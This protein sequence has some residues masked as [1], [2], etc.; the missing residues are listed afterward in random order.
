MEKLA[1]QT[2]TTSKLNPN[3]WNT[4]VVL[5]EAQSK[6]EESI[7]RFGMFKP[8]VCREL[9]DGRLEIIGGQH[10]WE[11]A[12]S[13]GM[14]E[15]PIVNLGL[16][17]DRKA[18]EISLVDNGRYGSDDS[19]RLAELLR[20][21]GTTD[22]LAEYLPYAVGDLAQIFSSTEVNLDDLSMDDDEEVEEQ[23]Q[24]ITKKS[25]MY[26]VM[27]FKVPVDDADFVRGVIDGISER[28]GFISSDSLTN[29]GD[30]LVWLC[31]RQRDAEEEE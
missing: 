28:Q 10:R 29:A 21:L 17:D 8:L 25:P 9:E 1:I 22:E 5:P 31:G 3:P 19:Q 30:A 15:V 11:A 4:N 7:R 18:K 24:E 23:V 16:I 12:K 27:R 14:E 26:Q 13:L 20:E 2:T 6:I